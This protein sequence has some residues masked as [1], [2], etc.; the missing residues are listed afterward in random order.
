MAALRAVVEVDESVGLP[1]AGAQ[2]VAG[3][4]LAGGLE[5]EGQDLEGLLLEFD[6]QAVAAKLSG[7]QVELEYAE[8]AGS[9][10]RVG[11]VRLLH[12]GV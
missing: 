1:E 10:I 3:N 9:G 12:A 2:V 11:S 4:D 8:A 6:A 5:E 7:A